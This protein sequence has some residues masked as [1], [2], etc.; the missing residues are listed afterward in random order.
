MTRKPDSSGF[1]GSLAGTISGFVLAAVLTTGA[2]VYA[3]GGY[4]KAM[5]PVLA[6]LAMAQIAVHLFFF[7]DIRRVSQQRWTL[8]ALVFAAWVVFVLIGESWWIMAHLRAN[9]MQ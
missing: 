3:T 1:A 7:L 4:G 8:L 6:G 5:L 9:M 2:F